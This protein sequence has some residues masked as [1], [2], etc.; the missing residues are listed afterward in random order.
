V[1]DWKT[2]GLARYV[3][4]TNAD[5]LRWAE[6]NI[7]SL[8][9]QEAMSVYTRLL[10]D[11]TIND[12]TLAGLGLIDLAFLLGVL[13]NR[14]DIFKLS[15]ET[16]EAWLYARVREFEAEPDGCLDI[17]AREHYKDLADD[18][19]MLTANRGWVTHGSLIAGDEVFSPNGRPVKVLALSPAYTTSECYELIFQ[20]SARVVAGAGHLWNLRQKH[21]PR[22]SNTPER[23]VEWSEATI[24]THKLVGFSGRLDVGV[25]QPLE[26]PE[27]KLTIDP[28]VL[29]AWLGDGSSDSA[30]LTQ[31]YSDSEL[32]SR[33]REKGVE[34]RENKSNKANTGIYNLGPGVRGKKGTGVHAELRRLGLIGN[35]HIPKQYMTASVS[36]RMELL[37][38]LMDTDGTCDTRGTA[39][40]VQVS[41]TLAM[42]VYEL[43]VSLAMRPRIRHYKN[44]GNGFYQVSLQ[45]HKDRNPFSLSRKAQRAIEPSSH[46]ECRSIISIK[47][48]PTVPTRCI[49]V[50]GG[51]YL[52]GRELIPTHNSTV[53]TF[54]GTIQDLLRDPEETTCIFSHTRPIAKKFLGQI[55]TELEINER[56]K[57]LYPDVL[58]AD[59]RRQSPKWSEDD[60]ITVK[61]KTNPREATVE[62]SGLVDGQP[63]GKHFGKL[64]YDDV[65]TKE[66]VSTPE[67]IKKTTAAWELSLNI[68]SNG[69]RRRTIGTRYHTNDSYRVMLDR[70]S[71]KLRM[72]PATK[73][74][75]E[76]GTPVLFSREVLA[77]KRRD[78]GPF[79]FAAQ[80][81]QNPSQDSVQGFKTDWLRYWYPREWEGMN[82]YIIVDPASKKKKTS[83]YT[84]MV[85]IGLASDGKYYVIDWI[86]DRLSLTERTNMLF[87]LHRTYTPLGVGYEEYGIQADIEHIQYVQNLEHYNFDITPL[88]GQIAKE[89]RIKGL[90]PVFET[91]R[92]ILP[93]GLTHTSYEKLPYDPTTTFVDEEY[94]DFPVALHDDAFDD[95]ARIQDPAMNVVWPTPTTPEAKP[96]RRDPWDSAFEEQNGETPGGFMGT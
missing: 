75:T 62:A 87:K 54:A 55:K 56:L 83:D 86:R 35:K 25:A 17:W 37:R 61:R 46:R 47:R 63:T 77:Q 28:Y 73:D 66:S 59:P 50:E 27:K 96:Q 67:Q 44:G 7:H 82:R 57:R 64:D 34:V 48:T 8:S 89:D 21:R 53:I 15:P 6:E 58:W 13:L 76:T 38:G 84:V 91:G 31:A 4:P 18:T 43:A 94:R 71:V 39:T 33:L 81:L 68:G 70:G 20:D 45:A 85:V 5:F 80:M 29:G 11:P 10:S 74:G 51:N 42:Q 30:R 14:R 32:I 41:Q 26:Y 1:A 95:L 19:P 60:G 69:G 92:M 40:F 22:I 12:K 36:Q 78:M 72:H 52:A 16:G 49:Q 9:M 88:G 79:T 90:L 23:C 24:P 2:P 93:A 3:T 65:V